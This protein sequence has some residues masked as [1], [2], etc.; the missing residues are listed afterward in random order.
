MQIIIIDTTGSIS[1]KQI[2]AASEYAAKILSDLKIDIRYE[3]VCQVFC[4]NF[5]DGQALRYPVADLAVSFRQFNKDCVIHFI[6]DGI[7]MPE[8]I[9]SVDKIYLHDGVYDWLDN[10]KLKLCGIVPR[11]K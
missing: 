11:T 10:V 8:E 4:G 3:I 1:S 2:E 7:M 6:T 5:D 9:A